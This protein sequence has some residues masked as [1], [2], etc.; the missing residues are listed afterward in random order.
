MQF[1]RLAPLWDDLTTAGTGDNIFTDNTVAGET[2]I[3]WNATNKA[4][5]SS[6]VNFAVTL[7]VDARSGSIWTGIKNLTPTVGISRGNN[8][9]VLLAS[10]WNAVANIPGTQSVTF[11]WSRALRYRGLRIS[12]Q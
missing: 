9:D 8:R 10:G 3:R 1:P 4:D 12:R 7:G 2:T 11:P 5:G 6:D